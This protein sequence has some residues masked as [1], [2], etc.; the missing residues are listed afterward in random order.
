MTARL[1]YVPFTNTSKSALA[2]DA[3]VVVVHGAVVA[4]RQVDAETFACAL[5]VRRPRSEQ[6]HVMS[7]LGEHL[8]DRAVDLLAAAERR[9]VQ[10]VHRDPQ[11]RHVVTIVTVTS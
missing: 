2:V 3:A 7:G 4:A 5:D 1:R 9:P 11:R 6:R 10:V 8:G